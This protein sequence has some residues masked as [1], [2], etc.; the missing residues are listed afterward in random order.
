MLS[1]LSSQF[2]KLGYKEDIDKLLLS[3]LFHV[4]Q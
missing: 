4:L 1:V 2:H 3:A